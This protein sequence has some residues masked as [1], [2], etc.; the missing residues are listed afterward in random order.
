MSEL[1][2]KFPMRGKY[3]AQNYFLFLF[4][5]LTDSFIKI[6][7]GRSREHTVDC[8]RVESVLV[9]N[10]AH[11]G[12]VLLSTIILP[13]I[14]KK[15]PLAKIGF[16]SGSWSTD[17]IKNSPYIDEIYY[18][19]HWKLY[20]GDESR[21]KS[22]IIYLGSLFSS[23]CKIRKAGYSLAVDLY[24]FYPNSSLLLWLSKIPIRIG[25][26]SGGFGT[27]YTHPLDWFDDKEHVVEYFKQLASMLN[28]SD[29]SADT[30]ALNCN[31]LPPN[32]F[33]LLPGSYVVV[34]PGASLVSK[35]WP[36]PKWIELMEFFRLRGV[37]VLITGKGSNESDIAQKIIAG[38]DWGINLV[39]QLSIAELI[40]VV[41]GASLLVG[42]DSFAGHL[43]AVLKIPFIVLMTGIAGQQW[44]PYGSSGVILTTPV[45]CSPCY[46]ANGCSE[47]ICIRGVMVQDVIAHAVTYLNLGPIVIKD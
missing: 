32:N 41:K 27:L 29:W 33:K 2:R 4:L 30:I 23:A 34:H 10:G 47:M 36:I 13:G 28:I 20:R 39:N 45:P 38:A 25:Y 12:D 21:F 42:L 11:L 43:A 37:R 5:L 8:N 3:L 26:T 18:V 19:D 6:I 17:V 46:Q 24:F 31:L 14:R 1:S 7:R 44:A 16:L 40:Y 9:C 22:F 15:F 35:E